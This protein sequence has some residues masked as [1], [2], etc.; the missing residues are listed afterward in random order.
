MEYS[1]NPLLSWIDKAGH[2]KKQIIIG[3]GVVFVALAIGGMYLVYR[4]NREAQAHK[5]WVQAIE[6]CNA[7]IASDMKKPASLTSKVFNSEQEKWET[8]ATSAQR[9]YLSTKGASIAP[10]FLAIQAEAL[11]NLGKRDEAIMVLESAVQSMANNELKEGYKVKLA[12]YK[13]DSGNE[14]MVQNGLQMLQSIA[15]QD[16]HF[17]NDYVLYQL[18]EY[19]WTNQKFDQVKNYWKMLV[20]KFGPSVQTPSR[21]AMMVKDRLSLIEST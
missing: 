5:L 16:T 21:W 17:L 13:L 11:N 9:S 12:L 7:S 15:G 3:A 10:F 14:A 18:G 1:R 2:Y 6:L 8:I 19:F 20:L 4:K